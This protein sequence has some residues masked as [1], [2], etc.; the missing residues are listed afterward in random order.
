VSAGDF[1]AIAERFDG[2][3]WQL[4]SIPNANGLP[5]PVLAGVSCPSRLFCIAVGSSNFRLAG[6]T[7]G[8][9]WTP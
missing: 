8:A 3:S 9:K 7:L 6:D 4:E 5:I 2:A 1:I